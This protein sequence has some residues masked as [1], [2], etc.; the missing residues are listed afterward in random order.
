M[1]CG[2]LPGTGELRVPDMVFGPVMEP[3]KTTPLPPVSKT[4]CDPDS[5]PNTEL[6]ETLALGAPIPNSLAEPVM[7]PE[8]SWSSNTLNVVVPEFEHG[9]A[10]TV[11]VPSHLPVRPPSPESPGG[12]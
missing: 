8:G 12:P 3:R 1:P 5:C 10:V 7:S 6:E 11:I 2:Q 4:I 9:L